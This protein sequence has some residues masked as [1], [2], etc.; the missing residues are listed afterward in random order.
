MAYRTTT[1][2]K[3]FTSP[4]LGLDLL[5]VAKCYIPEK[6]NPDGVTLLFFHAA[7]SRKSLCRPLRPL[8]LGWETTTEVNCFISV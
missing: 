5:F 8:A 7:G 4:T 6:V 1:L 2:K 3:L